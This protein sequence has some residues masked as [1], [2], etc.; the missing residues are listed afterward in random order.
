M[1]SV[2]L[3]CSQREGNSTSTSQW[4]NT[5]TDVVLNEGDSFQLQ[6]AL[7]NTQ[8]V[9]SGSINIAADL[10]ITIQV[11]YYEYALGTYVAEQTHSEGK[12]LNIN[13]TPLPYAFQQVT[14]KKTEEERDLRQ[15]AYDS[16]F[17]PQNDS[18]K[19]GLPYPAGLYMLR[20]AAAGKSLPVDH[21]N[22]LYTADINVTIPAGV[23][24]P[25]NLAALI[26][27]KVSSV[28]DE[29]VGGPTGNNGMMIALTDTKFDAYGLV[30]IGDDFGDHEYRVA[31]YTHRL[32]PDNT[33][34]FRMIGASD[35]ELAFDGN[36]FKFN[37]LHSPMMGASGE[38]NG[39]TQFFTNPSIGILK[40]GGNEF[41]LSNSLKVVDC[42]CGCVLTDL[43]PRSFWA[44]LGFSN[45]HL[46]NHVLYNDE[47]Y[48]A[49]QSMHPPQYESAVEY[50][51]ARRVKPSVLNSDY[52]GSTMPGVHSYDLHVNYTSKADSGMVDEDNEEIFYVIPT[53]TT[54]SLVQTTTTDT[55]DADSNYVVDAS[56][57]YRVEA[58]TSINNDYKTQGER[59]GAVVGIINS[60]LSS[61]DWMIGDGSGISYIHTGVSLPVS[62]ITISIIDPTTNAPAVGLGPGSSVILQIIKAPP[63]QKE[64]ER[65]KKK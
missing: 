1:T 3:E 55:L 40:V 54:M 20:Q 28:F 18:S 60:S 11:A 14:V 35:F 6:Q 56:G 19:K 52:R 29:S 39:G 7:L 42:Y 37:N 53:D 31:S 62:G 22:E 4:T 33:T 49:F 15:T 58:V 64:K 46:E 2:I 63:Q 36:I 61:N 38:G 41:G 59:K 21:N 17:K 23:Y 57:F 34:G 5:F 43:Q 30:Q 16:E 12:Q 24:L 13:N 26:T 27:K 32:N 44:S 25:E 65:E 48:K 10:P 45:T 47:T 50:F 8:T 51:N 9:T